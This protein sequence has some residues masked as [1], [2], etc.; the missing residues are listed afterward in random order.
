[1]PVEDITLT[2]LKSLYKT[3]LK[4][5]ELMQEYA[6]EKET[7]LYSLVVDILREVGKEKE[8]EIGESDFIK[9]NQLLEEKSDT[10]FKRSENM[11]NINFKESLAYDLQK[12]FVLKIENQLKELYK[13]TPEKDPQGNITFKT[14]TG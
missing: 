10:Y 7:T 1:V 13:L 14:R 12:A 2:A 8:Q 9:R 4:E 3:E 5:L 6:A 11:I